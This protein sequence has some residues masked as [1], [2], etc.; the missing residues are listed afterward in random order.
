MNHASNGGTW[1]AKCVQ[2]FPGKALQ[3]GHA[4]DIACL[5]STD[6]SCPAAGSSPREHTPVS[7]FLTLP[8]PARDTSTRLHHV[9]S[10]PA[11]TGAGGHQ[12]CHQ[13]FPKLWHQASL[14]AP[15]SP[16]ARGLPAQNLTQ[17]GAIFRTNFCHN[18]KTNY[19][20]TAIIAPHRE[21]VRC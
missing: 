18:V 7:V 4:R 11:S 21:T 12:P 5:R 14:G 17:A 3:P 2:L 15:K 13:C 19:F 16:R 6:S 10:H 9:P 20:R 1:T 8:A